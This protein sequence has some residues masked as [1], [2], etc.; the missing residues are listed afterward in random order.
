MSMSPPSTR[1][2]YFCVILAALMWAVSGPAGKFLFQHGITPL[3]LVQIRVTLASSLLFLWLFFRHPSLLIISPKDIFYFAVLGVFG[4]AMVQFTYF[5]A[6]SKIKVAAAI[7]LQ[8]L[9]PALIAL[10]S[11]VFAREKLTRLTLL[12]IFGAMGGCYLVVG[13]YN[14]DLFSLNKMGVIGGLCAALSFAFYSIYG[15]RGMRR[16]SPWTVLFY[17]LFASALFWN[18]AHFAWN[19]APPP[20]SSL[21]QHYSAIQ[22]TWIIY[23]VVLGT[24]VPFGLYFEGISLI[25]STRA[26]ITATLEPIMAGVVS[27]LFLEE[28]M[29]PLQ[30]LGGILVIASVI[31]LQLRQEYD[32][33]APSFIR[34]RAQ[35]MQP[36]SATGTKYDFDHH[37]ID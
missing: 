21:R 16:Y 4:M 26:S 35:V 9:A 13:A 22:W 14:L 11:V 31:I 25:R 20:L 34:A 19:G 36:T 7:L 37:S 8:Y 32:D 5:F 33:K 23:I 29:Q 10:Y 1:R 30:L 6:I 15:E 2:G 28:T 24:A 12:A 3:Q 18:M 27:Y 17:A